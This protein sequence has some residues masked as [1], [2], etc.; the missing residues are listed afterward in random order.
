MPIP[1]G[2]I[3]LPRSQ[4]G[5]FPQVFVE[6]AFV[7]AATQ[8][9]TF[10][11]ILGDAARGILGTDV[12]GSDDEWTDISDFVRTID[13]SRVAT[14]QQ[15][16]LNVY[17]GGTATFTL[18]NQLGYFD[19]Q[20]LAGPFVAAG[21]T[22]IRPMIPVRVRAIWNGVTSYLFQGFS[23]SWTP[24]A[25]NF[26]P[27]Y[28]QTTLVCG[29]AF[30][31]FNGVTLPAAQPAGAGEDTG[32]RITR[33]AAAAGWYSSARGK[34]VIATGDSTL[35]AYVG[36]DTALNLMQT[37]A[38]SEAG[39]LYIDG[40]GR[41]VF[42]NRNAPSTDPRSSSVQGVFGDSPGVTHPAGTELD[43][44]VMTRPDDD[45][46]MANDI[47]A[48]IVGSSN[49][50]EVIDAASVSRFLFPRTYSRTDL[51]LQ[52][53][54]D[55]LNW[56]NYIAGL[57]AGD[58]FRFDQITIT[59]MTDP[60]DLWPQALGRDYGDRIQ[61]WRR[62][63]GTGSSS[64]DLFIRGVEHHWDGTSQPLWWETVWTT[65]RAFRFTGSGGDVMILGDA[66]LGILGTNVLG[67]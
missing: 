2:T 20:N 51:V 8:G 17:Q 18:D 7:P 47:Q 19:P 23:T 53:D 15:G 60:G 41:L 16:P 29:D 45:T 54:A 48:T 30:R 37:A 55:A 65:Q 56:A 67:F 6:A 39:D 43:C 26:G 33:I 28:D 62:P 10:D 61:V 21:Q 32:A 9:G 31:I 5:L 58:E 46:T 59:P 36:G 50:Q 25:Q 40:Q 22:Q 34:S 27:A 49:M 42:R 63:P 57:A 66:V 3:T 35:Q 4:A 11:L 1:G 38:D 13:I 14:R 52:T 64:E 12:L 24:P 44:A